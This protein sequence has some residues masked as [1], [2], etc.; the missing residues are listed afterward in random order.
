ME[1]NRK[2]MFDAVYKEHYN[3]VYHVALRY[4]G[5]QHTSED[6]THEV[7]LKYYLYT[8][9]SDV[10]SPRRWL[11][12]VGSRLALNYNKKY[13]REELVDFEERSDEFVDRRMNPEHVFFEKMWECEVLDSAE[14]ILKALKKKNEK[15]YDAVSY[16][17]GMAR[18][19]QEV[20]DAMG[21]SV[22]ALDGLLK[23][24]KNWIEKN[25][26]FDFNRINSK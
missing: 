21:I 3:S 17:Y 14:V 8:A 11:L 20:A 1:S 10:E 16:V 5:N 19:R 26:K 7:F 9:A 6:I 12:T 4:T 18:K 23:R 13:N 24:A 25:Y 15:W 2:A 22:M